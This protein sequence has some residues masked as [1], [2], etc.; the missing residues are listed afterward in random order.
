MNSG[1]VLRYVMMVAG[2][3]LLIIAVMS[4]AKRKMTEPFCLAWVFFSCLMILGG[5]LLR[6]TGISAYISDVGLILILL[7]G[8]LVVGA[9]FILSK[10]ISE[11]VRKNRELSMQVSL[12]NEENRRMMTAIE[13][14]KAN[15]KTDNEGGL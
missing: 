13:E 9:A 6:P 11:L 14:L 7:I 3:Y 2:L 1:D 4:L 15:R 10:S 5:I 8:A 12:I